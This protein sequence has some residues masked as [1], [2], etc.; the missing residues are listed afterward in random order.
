MHCRLLCFQNLAEQNVFFPVPVKQQTLPFFFITGEDTKE[1]VKK[2]S[3]SAKEFSSV[4]F[5]S[6]LFSAEFFTY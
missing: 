5:F 1:G 6:G 4:R 2:D 3:V